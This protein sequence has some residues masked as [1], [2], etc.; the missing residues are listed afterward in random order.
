MS[1]RISPSVLSPMSIGCA[2]PVAELVVS[3]SPVQRF[4][5]R[6]GEPKNFGHGR[7]SVDAVVATPFK[8]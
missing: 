5:H 2:V 3:V 6:R 1:S 7:H 8:Y 4:G